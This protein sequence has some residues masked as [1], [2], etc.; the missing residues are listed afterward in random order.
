MLLA[1]RNLSGFSLIE[2][3]A[4]LFIVSVAV[5]AALGLLSGSLR[6]VSKTSNYSRAL[7]HARSMMEESLAV[8]DPTE[9][10]E[11]VA[12][13][14]DM[15]GIRKVRTPSGDGQ[16]IL[17]EISVTVEWPPSGSV[18]LVARSTRSKDE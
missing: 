15:T 5:S 11:T 13:P 8:D 17:Y 16:I 6:A 7:V 9:L 10:D 3:I 4:A 18:S 1:R 14:D 2:V 12:L